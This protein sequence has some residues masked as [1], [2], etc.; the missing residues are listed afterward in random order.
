M[1]MQ[2]V[3]E[4]QV[5]STRGPFHH[6]VSQPNRTS[7]RTAIHRP[8]TA[9]T[10]KIPTG[11]RSRSGSGEWK[12]SSSVLGVGFLSPVKMGFPFL[13]FIRVHSRKFAANVFCA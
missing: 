10:L 3:A 7:P 13:L 5:H 9:A 2:P 4:C 12:S 11:F 8:A 6:F 1:L